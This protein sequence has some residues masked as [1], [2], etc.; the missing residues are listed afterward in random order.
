MM[1]TIMDNKRVENQINITLFA[2]RLRE[3]IKRKGYSQKEF[4]QKINISSNALRNILT[5]KNFP[6]LQTYISIYQALNIS[7]CELLKDS[8]SEPEIIEEDLELEIMSFIDN[9][10]DDEK[11]A[12]IDIMK[13]IRHYKLF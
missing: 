6:S 7:F 1:H 8:I 10:D 4:S 2:Y 9:S 13:I 11:R 3:T 5:G 12:L